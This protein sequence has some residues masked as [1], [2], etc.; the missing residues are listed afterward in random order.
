MDRA[1]GLYKELLSAQPTPLGY[2]A[3]AASLLKRKRTE[4]LLKVLTE[5]VTKPNGFEAVKPQLE[6]II[7]DPAFADEVLDT[8]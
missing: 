5:A 4:D 7:K 6:A 2:R 3:L 1:E 8:G